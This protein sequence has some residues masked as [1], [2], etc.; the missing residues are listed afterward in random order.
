M[1]I[2]SVCESFFGILGH[3]IV[4]NADTLLQLVHVLKF[5]TNCECESGTTSSLGQWA[6]NA[7]SDITTRRSF[8]HRPLIVFNNAVPQV[9]FGTNLGQQTWSDHS[10]GLK[11]TQGKGKLIHLVQHTLRGAQIFA[12]NPLHQVK[13]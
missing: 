9:A 7:Y 12:R 5:H 6:N 8:V 3:I 13:V 11:H 2:A 4:I 10:L 1:C